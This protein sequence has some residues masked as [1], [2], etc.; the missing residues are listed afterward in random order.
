MRRGRGGKE[1]KE[2]MAIKQVITEVQ[3]L[4]WLR[5]ACA[6]GRPE[7]PTLPLQEHSV[8]SFPSVLEVSMGR[9][10]S[11]FLSLNILY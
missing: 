3:P 4:P 6:S 2:G 11:F 5:C 8:L 1:A 10:E 7:G 9:F